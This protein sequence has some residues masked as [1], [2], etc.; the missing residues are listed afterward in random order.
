MMLAAYPV[1]GDICRLIGKMSEFQTELTLVQIK[2]KLFDEW[3]ERATLFHST[4]KLVATLKALGVLVSDKPGKY[5]INR[6]QVKTTD[7]SIF[8]V[9]S[10]MLIDAKGYYS[11]QEIN[12][13]DYLFPFDYQ[14]R[15]ETLLQDNR[16]MI[17][18]L[19]GDLSV[20]LK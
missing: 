15:K 9:Y 19:G 17:S 1:F 10:I 7:V 16:F 11:F 3:G 14:V 12:S 20:T 8:M 5:H 2:Q 4:D 6:H 13:L 18:N